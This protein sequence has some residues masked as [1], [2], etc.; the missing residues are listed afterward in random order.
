M[1]PGKARGIKCIYGPRAPK[2][3]CPALLRGRY[4]PRN[5]VKRSTNKMY[6]DARTP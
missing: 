3:A 6:Y 1:T 4:N 2:E 5:S